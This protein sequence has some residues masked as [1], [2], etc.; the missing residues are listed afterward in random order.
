MCGGYIGG[1]I[2]IME[3]NM[4]NTIVPVLSISARFPS[5]ESPPGVLYSH[6]YDAVEI[7]VVHRV[8]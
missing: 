5:E 3:K 1:Y 8:A 4:E 7:N 6:T 2:G